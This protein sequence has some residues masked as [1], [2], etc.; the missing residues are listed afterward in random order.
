MQAK[1]VTRL[2]QEKKAGPRTVRNP[3]SQDE[4]KKELR[5]QRALKP[6]KSVV[7]EYLMPDSRH[8]GF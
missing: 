5:E 1:T 6:A 3:K 8:F 2:E 7:E 4:I